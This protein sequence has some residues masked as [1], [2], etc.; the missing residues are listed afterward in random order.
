MLPAFLFSGGWLYAISFDQP[1]GECKVVPKPTDR[2]KGTKADDGWDPYQPGII[3]RLRDKPGR[4]G[5][6][7]GNCQE[8]GSFL[9]TEID[10]GPND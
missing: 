9:L 2:T 1:R 10:F 7:T 4:Q 6:T 3:V 8:A 5:T